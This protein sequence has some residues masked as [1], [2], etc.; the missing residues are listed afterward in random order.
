M[1]FADNLSPVPRCDY[2]NSVYYMVQVQFTSDLCKMCSTLF[3][4]L[5][6]KESMTKYDK[7]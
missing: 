2:C 1:G 6:V 5:R 3:N 7:V 4:L